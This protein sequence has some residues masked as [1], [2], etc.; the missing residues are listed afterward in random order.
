M[1]HPVLA[2]R[3]TNETAH[4]VLAVPGTTKRRPFGVPR[5]A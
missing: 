2:R 5:R 3:A 4:W 1:A